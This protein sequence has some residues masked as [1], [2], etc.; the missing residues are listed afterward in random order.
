MVTLIEYFRQ[1]SNFEL[2]KFETLCKEKESHYH[3]DRL[4]SDHPLSLAPGE[5][6][7]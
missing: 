7:L 1:L 4:P 6:N 5:K 2:S 3:D